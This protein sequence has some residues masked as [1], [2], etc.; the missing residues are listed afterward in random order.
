MTAPPFLPADLAALIGQ[1]GR[2]DSLLDI[3]EDGG[4]LWVEGPAQ[5]AAI[6]KRVGPTGFVDTASG[7]QLTFAAD[8]ASLNLE[9]TSLCRCD[10]GA[11]RIAL[12]Q[13]SLDR[14]AAIARQSSA[15]AIEDLVLLAGVVPG[16]RLDIRYATADNF[17]GFPVYDRAAAYARPA[18][19]AALAQV[20]ATLATQDYG[21]VIHDAYRPWS[22]TKLF[23]DVVP[24]EYRAF[25]ADPATGSKHNRGCAIDLAL[26][27]ARTGELLAMPS[28]YDEPTVRARSDYRGGASRARWHRDL[29]RRAMEASGFVVQPDEWWHFDFETWHDYPVEDVSFAMLGSG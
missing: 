24:P 9:G 14:H 28:R 18:V 2:P 22:V 17:M 25:V 11:E 23:W 16:V 20:Q 19:A 6:I 12:F 27:D 21:L 5:P 8:G 1:Y 7:R 29:L 26:C 13:H 15:R 3:F 10:V 4:S